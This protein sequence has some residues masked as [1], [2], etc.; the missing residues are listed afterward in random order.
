MKQQDKKLPRSDPF[1][2]P[3]Y[4]ISITQ[5]PDVVNPKDSIVTNCSGQLKTSGSRKN[6]FSDLRLRSDNEHKRCDP[7]RVLSVRS[8][9]HL[10]S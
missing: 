8:A 4:D 6:C 3:R 1:D 9:L 5:R 7:M 2:Q 10:N